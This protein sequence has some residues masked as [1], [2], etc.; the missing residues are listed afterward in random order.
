[1]FQ[2]HHLIVLAVALLMLAM[3]PARAAKSCTYTFTVTI[4]SV[5]DPY[6]AFSSP[7]RPC[8]CSRAASSSAAP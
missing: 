6:G 7:T 3:A 2:R 4:T 5:D 8:P 1:M